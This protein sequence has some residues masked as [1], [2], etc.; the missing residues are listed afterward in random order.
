MMQR[1][2]LVRAVIAA[3]RAA[4]DDETSRAVRELDTDGL[5]ILAVELGV[6]APPPPAPALRAVV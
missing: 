3:M 4:D 2:V 6:L 5:V 1:D